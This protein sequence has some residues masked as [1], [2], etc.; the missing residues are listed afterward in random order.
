M[1]YLGFIFG[2]FGLLAYLKMSELENRLTKLERE[3]TAMRGTSYH[4]DRKNLVQAVKSYTGKKVSIELK[5]DNEDIDIMNYGNTRH[6]SNIILDSDEEWLLL[7][8]VTPK[9]DKTKLIRMESVKRVSV[10][11]E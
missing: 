8:I 5:E 7:K 9:G 2:I 10:I 1:E 11:S 6:G 3:L 4:E